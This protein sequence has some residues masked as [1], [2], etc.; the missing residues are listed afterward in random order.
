MNDDLSPDFSGPKVRLRYGSVSGK[1]TC[2]SCQSDVMTNK[3]RLGSEG[4]HVYDHDYEWSTILTLLKDYEYEKLY[5]G[6][7]VHR[8][9]FRVLSR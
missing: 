4:S 8:N 3:L 5:S 6:I 9:Y 7:D 2:Y 1:G